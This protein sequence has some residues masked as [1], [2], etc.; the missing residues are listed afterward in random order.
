MTHA[1]LAYNQSSQS[2]YK[3]WPEDLDVYGRII[4]EWILRKIRWE[5][6]DWMHLTQDRNHWQALVNT[7]KGGEF[8]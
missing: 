2:R 1:Y 3:F 5:G 8:I 6:V 7:V 4:L